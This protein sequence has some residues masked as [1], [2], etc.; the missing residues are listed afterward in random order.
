[1][2]VKA[3]KK[4]TLEDVTPGGNSYTR[5]VPQ[6]LEQLQW[7]SDTL[8]FV[9]D[10]NIISLRPSTQKESVLCSLAQLNVALEK[11]SLP[12][13]QK[14]PPFSLLAR[15]SVV[16]FQLKN[17]L[18]FYDAS[19]GI[20]EKIK[21]KKDWK[22]RD[23]CLQNGY[24]AF[25]ENN[26][27]YIISPD[28]KKKINKE[29]EK[30]VVYGQAVHRNEWGI[31]KGTF[32]SPKGNY[33]AF[34]RMDESMVADYTL[35]DNSKNPPETKIIKYPAAGEN[36]HQ[37]TIGIYS[38]K[39]E[40]TFYLRTGMPFD[41]FFTNLV[42]STD[43][44]E[45]YIAELNRL[46]DSCTLKAYTIKTGE[47]R[48]LFTE[49]SATYVEPENPPFFIDSTRFVWQSER[50][51]HN[52]LYLYNNEGV[53]LRPLTGGDWDVLELNGYNKD[54]ESLIF[55]STESSPLERNI[56]KLS[57]KTGEREKLTTVGGQHQ[58]LVSESGR[59]VLD[60][61][62]A[63]NVPRKIDIIQINGKARVNLLT[64]P[65]PYDGYLMPEV[66]YGN[67]KAAD[68]TT[69]LHYRLTLPVP[70]DPNKKYPVV[71]HVYGGPHVQLVQNSWLGGSRGWE[72]YMAQQGFVMFSLDNRGSANRGQ[73][74]EQA[75]FKNIGKA[76]MDDQLRGVAFLKSLLFIDTARVGVY[77]W[78]FGGF[79]CTQLMCKAPQIFK[80]GIA[81]GA[82]IDWR[83]YEV[84]YGE[85]YMQTPQTNP[86]GYAEND[87]TTFAHSLQGKFMMIHCELDPVVRIINTERFLD[88]AK[89][90]GKK[91]DFVR[92]QKHE[93]NV[94][95][96]D[97]V[98]LFEKVS[99]FFIQ[100]LGE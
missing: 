100:N 69:D 45:L 49:T 6:N 35:T 62:S 26:D 47:I 53:L 83:F 96:K 58:G 43:E 91:V 48:S 81:G 80:V 77:G 50:S 56:Y 70:F 28:K 72:L 51:G 99:A 52:H 15:K 22:N 97:R 36:S 8:V 87:L 11:E 92:Y 10:T 66:R 93:H 29:S 84:M 94:L 21:W 14:I 4:F 67:L 71:M 27:L 82:V 5:F 13:Q 68:D 75:V 90:A 23:Y 44:K 88:A 30:E 76:P 37:V 61:Y 89:T 34:Y 3:Q 73:A 20:V 9:R 57:L 41:R 64:A 16:M 17:Y 32:W 59:F 25:T 98:G 63:V 38:V 33:L 40:K 95:G 42:W 65:N 74:F 7:W 1:M 31:Q 19:G 79:M 24:A 12:L 2:P 46:Q 60:N 55:G 86:E 39:T 18:V 54:S 78:S 85:R